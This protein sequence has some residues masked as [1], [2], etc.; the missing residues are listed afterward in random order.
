MGVIWDYSSDVC[1][2]WTCT[3]WAEPI[4]SWW[5]LSVTTVA[6]QRLLQEELMGPRCYCPLPGG[7]SLNTSSSGIER[8]GYAGHGDSEADRG[9]PG[10]A[11]SLPHSEIMDR[12]PEDLCHS[13][14]VWN[15]LTMERQ[16]F[17]KT[18]KFLQG[19]LTKDNVLLLKPALSSHIHRAIVTSACVC[20]SL[21]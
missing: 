6:S 12:V 4:F 13:G 11:Q 17:F 20:P 2:E 21:L 16:I 15:Q 8:S 14:R 18:C 3:G 9:G 5:H 19:S 10:A 1:I 7:S